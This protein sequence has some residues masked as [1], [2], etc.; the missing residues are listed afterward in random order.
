MRNWIALGAILGAFAGGMAWGQGEEGEPEIDLL[1]LE[2]RLS[3]V[4]REV[5]I[6]SFETAMARVPGLVE[7]EKNP[8]D[9]R[10]VIIRGRPSPA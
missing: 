5:K 10:S 4:K 7:R 8:A 1:D 9:G 3:Q 6:I 2:T